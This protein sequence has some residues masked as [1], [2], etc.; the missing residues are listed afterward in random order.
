MTL[1]FSLFLIGCQTISSYFTPKPIEPEST[2]PKKPLVKIIDRTNE[3]Q[4]S[5]DERGTNEFNL[6]LGERRGYSVLKFLVA[7]GANPSQFSIISYGEERP[8]M[9]D[10]KD[11]QYFEKNR[12]VEFVRH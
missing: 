5:E 8:A 6:A 7:M 1:G 12:R 4:E 10:C 3:R 9:I 2:N 11:E